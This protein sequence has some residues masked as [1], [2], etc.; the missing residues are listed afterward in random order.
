MMCCGSQPQKE[1]RQKSAVAVP[2][3]STSRQGHSASTKKWAYQATLVCPPQGCLYFLTKR[4]ENA[5][6]RW[7]APRQVDSKKTPQWRRLSGQFFP[8]FYRGKLAE[9]FLESFSVVETDMQLFKLS[10]IQFVSI[11]KSLILMDNCAGHC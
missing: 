7:S 1:R 2:K 3:G 4:E 8:V 10:M 6:L 11:L 9:P 5:L